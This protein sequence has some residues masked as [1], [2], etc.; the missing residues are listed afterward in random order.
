[1]DV[2]LNWVATASFVVITLTANTRT[3]TSKQRALND[4]DFTFFHPPCNLKQTER[5]RDSWGRMGRF[6]LARYANKS[7]NEH[8]GR[9]AREKSSTY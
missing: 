2:L 7:E 1:M 9:K 3:Y 5:E 8:L 4:L 6:M